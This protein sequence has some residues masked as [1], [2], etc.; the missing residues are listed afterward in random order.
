MNEKI[1][2]GRRTLNVG[3]GL[4]IR[5]NRLSMKVC[6][7]IF[8]EIV[9]PIV[10][11]GCESWVL[12][13]KDI[14]NPHSFQRFAGKCIQRFHK[15]SPNSSA[16]YGLEWLRITTFIAIKKLFFV[17]TVVKMDLDNFFRKIF[18]GRLEVFL[19]N[20]QECK[21]NDLCSPFYDIFNVCDEFG[22]IKEVYDMLTC[23]KPP[24]SKINWLNTVWNRAWKMDDMYWM[25]TNVLHKN[26]NFLVGI[27]T[28]TVYVMT[29]NA[30]QTFQR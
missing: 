10:T 22:L 5:K 14:E 24:E 7:I 21:V 11:F 9:I 27:M 13:E 12:S 18:L 3:T 16:F 4:G 8:W 28:S 20:M 30:G 23:A 15:R 19:D 29:T 26:N 6:N 2:K 1:S 17:L 25:M